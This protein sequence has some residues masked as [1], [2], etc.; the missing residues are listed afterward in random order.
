MRRLAVFAVTALAGPALLSGSAAAK[1]KGKTIK[2][3][4]TTTGA[5]VPYIGNGFSGLQ[6]TVKAKKAVCVTGR[7]VLASSSSFGSIVTGSDHGCRER[8]SRSAPCPPRA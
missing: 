7:N 8:R 2:V 3:K 5:L 1:P 6:G 4:T